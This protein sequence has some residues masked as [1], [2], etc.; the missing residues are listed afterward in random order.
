MTDYVLINISDNSVVERADHT[1]FRK[2]GIPPVLR[3]EKNMKWLEGVRVDPPAT[4]DQIK[5][6]PTVKVTAT[7]YIETWATRN[8]TVV[9][10]KKVTDARAA[11][12]ARGLG[13][14]MRAINDGT[15][16]PGSNYTDEQMA[17]LIKEHM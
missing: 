7:K 3:A 9:E 14:L 12:S 15:F 4:A 2:T 8:K 6:G 17:Q 5:T 11:S 1:R 13:P 10:K 16:I